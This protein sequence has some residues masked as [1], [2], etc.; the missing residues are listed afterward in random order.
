[1]EVKGSEAQ[2]RFREKASEG[3]AEQKHEPM[4][5]NRIGGVS[6]GQAGK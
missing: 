1:M 5:K 6:V 4:E 3:S 2:G